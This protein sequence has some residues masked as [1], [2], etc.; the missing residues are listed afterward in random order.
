MFSGRSRNLH[1]IGYNFA[2]YEKV[3]GHNSVFID[4]DTL[5]SYGY[6]FP[7]AKRLGGGVFVINS[8]PTTNTT[9]GHRSQ[10]MSGIQS[11]GYPFIVMCSDCDINNLHTDMEGVIKER[12]DGL[13]KCRKPEIYLTD[14]KDQFDYYHKACKRL[15]FVPRFPEYDEFLKEL[16]ESEPKIKSKLIEYMMGV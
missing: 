7:L 4:G 5:Y 2:R 9:Y 1:T 12:V 10:V 16:V 6:H 3:P 14:M 13:R 8:N 15:E 11:Y